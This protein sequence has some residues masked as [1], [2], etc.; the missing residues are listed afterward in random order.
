MILA[1]VPSHRGFSY[2]FIK[3][4]Y[5]VIDMSRVS[6]MIQTDNKMIKRVQRLISI[7]EPKTVILPLELNESLKRIGRYVA[8]TNVD[9][10]YYAQ[11][12]VHS[13]FEPLGAQTNFEIAY[14]LAQSFPKY[15]YRLPQNNYGN[16]R[17]GYTIPMWKSL[18]LGM[19]HLMQ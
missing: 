7:Y 8:T 2:S 5:E 19:T 9:L 18:A 1:I 12:D 16:E 13:T 4:K 10:N 17:E 14:E 6:F 15:Q 11:D 3:D